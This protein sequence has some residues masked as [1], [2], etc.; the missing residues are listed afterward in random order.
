[1]TGRGG[2]WGRPSGLRWRGVA[3]VGCG[4]WPPRRSPWRRWRGV[5][6]AGC[7]V[8]WA[9]AWTGWLRSAESRV[10]GSLWLP[11]PWMTESSDTGAGW[12]GVGV[13]GR[14]R[15]MSSLGVRRPRERASPGSRLCGGLSRRIPERGSAG[16]CGVGLSSQFCG[17]G[18][19]TPGST[20]PGHRPRPASPAH[21]CPRARLLHPAPPGLVAADSVRASSVRAPADSVR[22]SSVRVP[23]D[24][25]PHLPA[26]C[27]PTVRAPSV[28]V[29]ARSVRAPSVRAPARSTPTRSTPALPDPALPDPALPAPAPA[30]PALR[31]HR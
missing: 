22:A 8:G 10:G 4:R 24:S 23:A 16:R 18:P 11:A 13:P 28:L 5:A 2:W 15:W 21:P 19:P 26:S 30:H 17:S 9:S 25:T 27:P 1:V 6:A 12:L 14:A 20:A 7:G 31:H 3:A 29:P